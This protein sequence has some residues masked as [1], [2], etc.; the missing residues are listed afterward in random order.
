M[1]AVDRQLGLVFFG[2]NFGYFGAKTEKLRDQWAA[3]ESDDTIF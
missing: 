3:H 2:Y 1:I